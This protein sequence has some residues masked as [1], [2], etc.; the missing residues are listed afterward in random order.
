MNTTVTTQAQAIE[1]IRNAIIEFETTGEINESLKNS[2]NNS[3]RD[4][5]V[6][7][8]TMGLTYENHSKELILSFLDYLVTTASEIESVSINAVRA[9]FLYRLGDTAKAFEALNK[10]TAIDP[11]YSLTML[12]R[13]VFGSGWPA[14]AFETMTQ[15]LHPKVVAG[16][17]EGSDLVIQ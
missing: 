16:I 5:Q 10:A 6:R 13:R 3:L 2:V 15:E 4:I 1:E 14:G 11:S 17:E 9:S 12:L 8:F 7:D